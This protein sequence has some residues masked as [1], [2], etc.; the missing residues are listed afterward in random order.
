MTLPEAP[1]ENKKIKL[2]LASIL[3]NLGD[4]SAFKDEL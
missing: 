3:K 4:I 1:L 2:K